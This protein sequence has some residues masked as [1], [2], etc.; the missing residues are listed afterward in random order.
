MMDENQITISQI[1]PE[2]KEFLE[3]ILVSANMTMLDEQV[4]NDMILELYAQLDDY[5]M[6]TI[7]EKLDANQLEE[8]TK[9][10]E[11]GKT[12]EELQ[13]YLRAHI[14]NATEIFANAMIEFRD[15]YLGKVA[16]VNDDVNNSEKAAPDNQ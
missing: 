9:M 3:E 15:I 8:F 7:V 2:I 12:R 10:A 1:P 11:D 13:E 16:E 14:P 6:S 5:M 4:K